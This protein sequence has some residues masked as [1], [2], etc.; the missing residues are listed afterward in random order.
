MHRS[1]SSYFREMDGYVSR[2]PLILWLIAGVALMS[3]T[4]LNVAGY[5]DELTD[6]LFALPILVAIWS[7]SRRFPVIVAACS[8]LIVGV[9]LLTLEPEITAAV[10]RDHALVLALVWTVAANVVWRM[11][12][13]RRASRG[14][15]LLEKMVASSPNVHYVY[16]LVEQ[17]VVYISA[18][19]ETALGLTADQVVNM[20][21][22]VVESLGMPDGDN[23]ISHE[24]S[25]WG[26]LADNEILEY[27]RCVR[28]ASGESR[29]L[30]TFQTVLTRAADG[31]PRLIVGSALDISS[32]KLAEERMRES[33]QTLA[34]AQK[35]AG[36]GNWKF[37]VT[38][39]AVHWS[40]SCFELFGYQPQE[41]RPDYN[42]FLRHVHADDRERV[43]S[44]IERS[45]SA[46]TFDEVF[47]IVTVQGN[48]LTIHSVAEVAKNSA[49]EPVEMLG[50]QH[51]ITP[52]VRS[53]QAL[54]ESQA[55]L[56]HAQRAAHIGTWQFDVARNKLIWSEETYRA[57]G[58]E[59]GEI[60]PTHEAFLQLVHPADR[61]IV[62]DV[63]HTPDK[64][65]FELEFRIVTRNGRER[66]LR[67][68]GEA[69]FDE[70]GGLTRLS[71][72]HYD[73]TE[74]RQA[75][76]QYRQL[77]RA[78]RT[79]SLCNQTLVRADDEAELLQD[80]CNL[81]VNVGEYPLAWVGFAADDP[82]K[83]VQLVAQAGQTDA[84][85]Q[86]IRVSWADDEYGNG[87]AGRAIRSGE[88]QVVPDIR[89][90]G[91]SMPWRDLAL[92]C[93][94]RAF[95]ALP[96]RAQGRIIGILGVGSGEVQAF[97][98]DEK[99]LLAELAN[100]LA[101]GVESL[102]LRRAHAQASEA[103][104]HSEEKYRVLFESMQ[105]GFAYCRVQYDD[106]GRLND[107]IYLDVNE[108]FARI[109]GTKDIIGKRVTEVFPGIENLHPELFESYDRV[110][111]TG[112]PE[113]FEFEFTPYGVWLRI[114]AFRPETGYFVAVFENI[115]KR[116]EAEQALRKS[117]ERYRGLVESQSDLIIRVDAQGRFTF[118]NDAYCRKYGLQREE[119][120]GSQS[121]KPLV[122]PEDLPSAIE[123]IKAL[124]LPPHRVII[125]QRT[126]TPEG[127][128]WV[129]WE[130]CAIR[131]EAGNI[132]EIQAVGRD[133]HSR[134]I[135]EK[136][137]RES[138][139]RFRSLIETMGEG[140]IVADASEQI[141]LS[142]PA[143]DR[144]FGL[145]AGEL[146]GRKLLEFL[147]EQSRQ[148][149]LDNT[150]RRKL[151]ES[152]S[153]ELEILRQDGSPRT[154]LVTASPRVSDSGDYL[155]AQGV[156]RDI[157]DVKLAR[158]ALRESE[159]RLRQ[160]AETMP[161]PITVTSAQDGALLYANRQVAEL[162]GGDLKEAMGKSV[163][164]FYVN[165]VQAHDFA[166][167]LQRI[168][169]VNDLEVQLRR[170]DGRE[171]WV[172]MSARLLNY[173]GQIGIVSGFYDIT[174]R[175]R[176]EEELA[177]L[178]ERL[179]SAAAQ[180]RQLAADA[181]LASRTKSAFLANMS[182]ELRTPM[183]GVIGFAQLLLEEDLTPW[184]E[185]YVHAIHSSAESLL[186]ILNG[187]LDLSKVES[188]KL[189]LEEARFNPWDVV[190]STA[191]LFAPQAHE[192]NIELF[193]FLNPNI[194]HELTGDPIRLRQVLTNLMGNAVKFTESGGIVI[195]A[196][197]ERQTTEA[198]TLRFSVRDSG[199]GIPS[200][201]QAA[202]FERF[203]QADESRTRR[204]GGAG[205][206]LAISKQL[207]EAM[208]GHIGVE[209]E[210]G[211][212]STFWFE[213]TFGCQSNAAAAVMWP[214]SG[215]NVL[216]VE[217]HETA[218]T[219]LRETLEAHHCRVTVATGLAPALRLLREAVQHQPFN[220]VVMSATLADGKGIA[221]VR[222]IVHDPK[223][224]NLHIIMIASRGDHQ[225]IQAL[226]KL[227][228][229]DYLMRPVKQS[230]LI[231]M[232]SATVRSAPV[233]RLA[234]DEA[235]GADAQ[236]L[237]VR[238]VLVVE[239]NSVNQL[240]MMKLL[241]RGGFAA[242][243]AASGEH[244]LGL[245]AC[246]HYDLVLMDV[247]MPELDGYECTRRIRAGLHQPSIPIVAMTANAMK[248]DREKC[249]AA[250][251][252]DYLAK[253]IH[254]SDLYD[255]LRRWTV[256]EKTG[257]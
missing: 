121:Y 212:G 96:L 183:N 64:P 150:E 214:I 87:P 209:S 67:S 242:D 79:I 60:T 11:R 145:E 41:V 8:T 61:A 32:R 248:G 195:R 158:E 176:A 131:D 172:L 193:C 174:G 204:Y 253:P 105:E 175:K 146:I 30:L 177:A 107:W 227:G 126:V 118:V 74:Q 200:E 25:R 184:Q 10:V 134:K 88:T 245:L 254:A 173:D 207:V 56:L 51:D 47:R 190:E 49:G 104:R 62:Q 68:R 19:I 194:P 189:E 218:R 144:I 142:N 129:E 211:R 216:V 24:L 127:E 186:R 42:L 71:G 95:I 123:A 185:D 239:D 198:L 102:R 206:G 154:V 33:E 229:T 13:E 31:S 168:G 162:I 246:D 58:F 99:N 6:L 16:D 208:G 23:P 226:R 72:C 203:V 103:L 98:P 140:L 196:D 28:H 255:K 63:R 152:A 85:M 36:I 59:P 238:R 27:E 170:T 165:Q 1:L 224:E 202:I 48:E 192:K 243:I 164:P 106:Q 53:E 113:E 235:Q 5:H 225:E 112:Q 94:L 241:Q 244:A 210:P 52:H 108:A 78:L 188:G 65:D 54:R 34:R 197:L 156:F 159:D 181:M 120:I 86:G 139:T 125:E 46:G 89:L 247:Q 119:V 136:A 180:S 15:Q 39:G 97:G 7:R 233:E 81:I 205:L 80:I 57:F 231:G 22:E 83:S 124:Q 117:E 240:L 29:W 178:N 133:I 55:F 82:Q 93:G 40:E 116:K 249:L 38:T 69:T 75:E 171:I 4:L 137:L 257:E 14:L 84:V 215:L 230:R 219:Y 43:T 135:A 167:E 153:Y 101:F 213:L 234:N 251:M 201:K 151:G 17:R 143:A 222:H 115:T 141:L 191:D 132:I 220:A 149:V 166:G 217:S 66:T 128:R 148:I 114:S 37:N 18:R 2:T 237:S 76:D 111:R 91:H 12:T 169:Y 109:I 232:L 160:I 9:A 3:V 228:C 157:T 187:I 26:T 250:G 100:D 130:D 199:I 110:A 50:A 138:E 163:V 223:L 45:M 77:N 221:V 70:L 236:T 44:A 155:G 21:S 182:H 252:N 161:I 35:L 179:R 20:G 256:A 122:H 92:Q 90:E 73:I 147:P